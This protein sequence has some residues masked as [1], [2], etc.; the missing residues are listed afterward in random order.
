[1]K[2]MLLHAFIGVILCSASGAEEA[3]PAPGEPS[4]SATLENAVFEEKDVSISLDFVL[5]NQT[6]KPIL[7]A[8]RWN[9]WGA[10]QWTIHATTADQ[11]QIVFRNPMSNWKKNFLSATTIEPGKEMRLRC[12]LVAKQPDIVRDGIQILTPKGAPVAYTF[13]M[14]LAGTFSASLHSDGHVTTNW[15]GTIKTAAV[16]LKK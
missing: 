3:V 2:M 14:R 6:A 11:Q 16:V 15:E 4:F 9:S 13:P 10:H 5:K 1:M 8:E 12:R 7:I